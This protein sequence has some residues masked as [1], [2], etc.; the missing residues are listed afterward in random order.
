M[1]MTVSPMAILAGARRAFAALD[2]V[3]ADPARSGTEEMIPPCLT[4]LRVI[5]SVASQQ[6]CAA[7]FT[8]P[9]KR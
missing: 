4:Y 9:L 2:V 3:T 8:A 7:R 6:P 1:K 5:S